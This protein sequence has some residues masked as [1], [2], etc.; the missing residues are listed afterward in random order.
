MAAPP[1]IVT[2]TFYLS[3]GTE[4]QFFA[5]LKPV[6]DEIIQDE[7]CAYFNTFRNVQEPGVI[8]LT[9]VWNCDEEY[10]QKV[11]SPFSHC[12]KLPGHRPR[13]SLLGCYHSGSL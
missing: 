5:A 6:F 3:S 7:K 9:E 11:S 4:G 8:R 10:L 13:K 2:V 1:L 12:G